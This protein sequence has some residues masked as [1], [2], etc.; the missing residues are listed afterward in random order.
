MLSHVAEIT[1]TFIEPSYK[2][3]YMYRGEPKSLKN[4]TQ[5]AHI[6]MYKM[7]HSP[8]KN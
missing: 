5:A 6:M 4:T 8:T 7:I 3:F 1:Y 2:Y